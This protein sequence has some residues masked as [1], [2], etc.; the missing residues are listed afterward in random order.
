[1]ENKSGFVQISREMLT[2]DQWLK[3]KFTKSQAFI[4]L[5]GMAAYRDRVVEFRGE[6]IEIPQKHVLISIRILSKRWKWNRRTVAKFLNHLEEKED[7]IYQTKSNRYTVIEVKKNYLKKN[8]PHKKRYHSVKRFKENRNFVPKTPNKVHHTNKNVHHNNQFGTPHRFYNIKNKNNTPP[9]VPNTVK[10]T[11]GG[12]SRNLF[13]RQSNPDSFGSDSSPIRKR[14]L[15]IHKKYVQTRLEK[16]KIRQSPEIYGNSLWRTFEDRLRIGENA[17]NDFLLSM[18][19]EVEG[20]ET[21]KQNAQN[22]KKIS[23]VCVQKEKTGQEILM[24]SNDPDNDTR[25]R[26]QF[27]FGEKKYFLNPEN[28]SE[29][30]SGSPNPKIDQFVPSLV[31]T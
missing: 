1:M 6:H 26:T 14:F 4:D 29:Q 12:N 20:W 11:S 30:V 3:Q 16:K 2:S 18:E 5:M 8:I 7:A 13:P 21:A 15:G 19:K 23:L 22:A 24:Y 25:F 28:T 17:V 31:R 10:K 9:I 27:E